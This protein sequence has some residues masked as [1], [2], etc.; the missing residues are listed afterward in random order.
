MEG[1]NPYSNNIQGFV[2]VQS[3]S[4]ERISS[5]L[6]INKASDDASSLAIAASL[7]VQQSSLSQSLSNYNSGIAMSNI[8]QSGIAQ[9]KSILE[10]IQTE[11]LKST[12]GTMSEADKTS[13]SNNI[14]KLLDQYEQIASSTNYNG[15]KL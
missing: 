12:N 10:E 4:L 11:T 8:A 2:G 7:G 3:S 1:I 9:Q 6:A 5:A 14:N 13:I 15:E